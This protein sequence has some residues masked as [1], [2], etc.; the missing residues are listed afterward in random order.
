MH[1]QVKLATNAI[2]QIQEILSY[3]SNILMAPQTAVAWADLLEDKI[4]SLDVMPERF[5]FID[6]E[7]WKTLGYHKMSVK[8]FL[9]YYYIDD[10]TK[11]V[12][13][14]AVI[15]GRRDQLEALRDI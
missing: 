6:I 2:I 9:V 15:Y 7:P 8:N 5:P 1:Y 14:T 4:S 3:I 13:V 12:W 10:N 11:T